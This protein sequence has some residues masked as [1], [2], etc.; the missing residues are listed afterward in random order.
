[1]ACAW[2]KFGMMEDCRIDGSLEDYGPGDGE[3]GDNIKSNCTQS[4]VYYF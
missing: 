3:G 2:L 4:W 1:M